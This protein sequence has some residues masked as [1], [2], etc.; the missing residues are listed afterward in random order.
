M[1]NRFPN[2]SRFAKTYLIAGGFTASAS[3]SHTLYYRPDKTLEYAV[4]NGIGW[5][6]CWPLFYPCIL[7][8][9]AEN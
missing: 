9:H 7:I 5:G 2:L 8:W 3:M 1:L 4:G 6:V